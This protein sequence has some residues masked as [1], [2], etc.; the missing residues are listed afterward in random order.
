M[1]HTVVNTP[2]LTTALGRLA[3]RPPKCLPLP[4]ITPSKVSEWVDRLRVTLKQANREAR[5]AFVPEDRYSGP[6]RQRDGQREEGVLVRLL[7]VLWRDIVLPILSFVGIAQKR[8]VCSQQGQC[9][10]FS[11][12]SG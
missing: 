9:D 6:S 11:T 1:K 4:A 10:P 2:S 12:D 5:E 7:G 3:L 8:Q